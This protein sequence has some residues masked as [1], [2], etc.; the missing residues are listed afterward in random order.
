MARILV[1]H[2]TLNPCGGGERVALH[3]VKALLEAGHEVVLGVCE[4]TDWSRVFKISGVELPKVPK[5]IY[6]VREV[7][8]FGIYQRLLTA[9]H[10]L[11]LRGDVDV[12]INTHGDALPF[13]TA[14]VTYVH[15]PVYTLLNV[16]ETAEEQKYYRSLFWRLYFE[17]YRKIQEKFASKSFHSTVV[18]ANS[19]FTRAVIRRFVGTDA[20]V[21]HPPVEVGEYLRAGDYEKEDAVAV[22]GRFT[23]EKRQ[24]LVPFIAKHLKDVKFYLIGT[25]TPSTRPYFEKIRSL[26]R[27]FELNNVVLYPNAPHDLKLKVLAR[28]K[29]YL[30]LMKGEHFGISVVEGMAAGCVP[31]VHMSGGTWTDIVERGRYGVGY[32]E[33]DPT[34]IAEAVEKALDMWSER[35]VE[36]IVKKALEFSDD[37]FRVKM[38][39]VVE[40]VLSLRTYHVSRGQ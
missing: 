4:K 34:E 24:D 20:L 37:K 10:A 23:P 11:K 27:K 13:V 26:V 32:R 17:P 19:N 14:D 1:L 18:I 38:L 22:V 16:A 3:T 6:I 33:L 5:E 40:K 15:Y 12:V 7:R 29:V 36:S 35:S 9:L 8:A 28:S 39:A 2:H 30:H 25:V 31:V 21:I